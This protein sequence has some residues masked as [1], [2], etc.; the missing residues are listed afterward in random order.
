MAGK[1]KRSTERRQPEGSGDPPSAQRSPLKA[2]GRFLLGLRVPQ[3]IRE[4]QERAKQQG[5]DRWQAVE[6]SVK[7][8][9]HPSR[10]YVL[11][12]MR[13][14]GVPPHLGPSVADWLS[15]PPA[16]RPSNPP[17]D[18]TDPWLHYFPDAE[19]IRGKPKQ[20]IAVYELR[21]R[22]RRYKRLAMKARP[23][24][25]GTVRNDCR[26]R[27]KNPTKQRIW[28]VNGPKEEALRI[29][30]LKHSVSPHTLREWERAVKEAEALLRFLAD[31]DWRAP[32][33]VPP[34]SPESSLPEP[35]HL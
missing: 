15:N 32:S 17:F 33:S 20:V 21:R 11:D 1:R 24:R 28:R 31:F 6:S 14:H 23:R 7:A 10:E 19:V 29:A 25:A 34:K 22:W 3:E 2:I 5:M 9:R 8:G 16:H 26:P 13:R 35:P 27:F 30:A 12:L 4:A 18:P